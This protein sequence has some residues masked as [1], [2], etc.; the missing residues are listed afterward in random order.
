MAGDVEDVAFGLLRLHKLYHRAD[1][2]VDGGERT[3]L[4]AISVDRERLATQGLRYEPGHHHSVVANLTRADGVE[5]SH[6]DGGK[7][8]VLVVDK[9]EDLVD[10]L[11]GRGAPAQRAR[12]AEHAIV[13]FLEGTVLA[14]AVDLARRRNQDFGPVLLRRFEDVLRAFEVRE[15]GL[16]RPVHNELDADR[17]REVIDDVNLADLRVNLGRIQHR[18]I[19][20]AEA[21]IVLEVAD[22]AKAARG[23]VVQSRH[24][25]AAR[26]QAIDYVRTDESR[27]S[28]DQ[29][30]HARRSP[31]SGRLARAA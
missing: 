28:R 12:R 3:R 11:G 27:P 13:L 29:D 6:D 25:V 5:Q 18:S 24:L 30:S 4:A 16:Q 14:L 21:R 20:E 1:H 17:R 10:R 15:H 7:A 26:D 19:A 31:L 22:V 8:Q 9:S 23:E 2:V